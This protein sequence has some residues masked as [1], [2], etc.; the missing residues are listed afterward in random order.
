MKR[1]TYQ[2]TKLLMGLILNFD[3]T[4]EEYV[5]NKGDVFEIKCA[6]GEKD[7]WVVL[8]KTPRLAGKDL[9]IDVKEI[10]ECAKQISANKYDEIV[11]LNFKFQA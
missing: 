3:D 5:L 1:Q 8:T 6:L 7:Q 11:A 9:Q 4:V 2:V 10:N